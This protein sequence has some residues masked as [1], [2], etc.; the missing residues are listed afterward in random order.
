M[1]II[2]GI[3]SSSWMIGI[4]PRV[5]FIKNRNHPSFVNMYKYVLVYYKD[6]DGTEEDLAIRK[7]I[8]FLIPF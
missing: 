8:R 7:E 3:T 2:K 5:T 1:N 4:R 6:Q